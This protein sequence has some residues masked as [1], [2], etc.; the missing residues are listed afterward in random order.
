[1][2]WAVVLLRQSLQQQN[3]TK[4]QARVAPI[5]APGEVKIQWLKGASLA[6]SLA[7]LVMV[8]SSWSRTSASNLPEIQY[9]KKHIYQKH[10]K[11]KKYQMKL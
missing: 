9:I 5:I 7:S 10:Q 6:S 8:S 11:K 2:G 1:V 4:R 3:K